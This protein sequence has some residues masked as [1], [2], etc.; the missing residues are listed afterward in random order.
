[1]SSA[2]KHGLSRDIPAEIRRVVRRNSKF[3]CVICRCGFFQ[4][5]HIDPSFES[6]TEHN[7]DWICCLCGSCHDAVTRG[8]IS[9]ELVK[10]AYQRIRA[11]DPAEVK[12]PS[13]PLDFHTGDAVLV[14][15]EL[16]YSPAV[17]T[18]L[19]YHG[20]T[21]ISVQPSSDAG[22]PGG[23]NALFT[24]SQGAEVLRL[25]ENAWIGLTD[26]WDIEV[27]GRRLTVRRKLGEIV[28]Q[29]ALEP[30]GRVILERLDMRIHDSHILVGSGTYAVGRYV[31]SESVAWIHASI[32][33]NVSTGDG[34]AIE[35]ADPEE[36]ARRDDMFRHIGQS[37]ATDDRRIVVHSNAGILIKELGIAIA[38]LTGS[39]N[40][41]SLSVGT[42][43]VA[44]MRRLIQSRP[45]LLDHYIDT[46]DA[47]NN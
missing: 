5:E 21:I 4:Y 26:I 27:V 32:R 10:E 24:D 33:I 44:D 31:D 38:S 47:Q 42:R 15:G 20:E 8:R 6:A 40:L 17:Q 23:I 28:L 11:A 13:G 3:G 14:L 43:P 18:V 39:F 7:P 19:R 25:E 45:D 2:N 22:T 41:L 46:G 16:E 29:L 1:M 9:K 35:F 34:A 36:L 12:A 37:M 30:P